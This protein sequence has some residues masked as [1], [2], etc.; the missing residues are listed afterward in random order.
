M[1]GQ[2]SGSGV[3][4]NVTLENKTN[5]PEAVSV[6]FPS[7]SGEGGVEFGADFGR[8]SFVHH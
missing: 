2:Q 5:G 1:L 8:V 4:T 6:V 3:A 7:T